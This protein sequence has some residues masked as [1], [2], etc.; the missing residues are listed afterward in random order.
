LKWGDAL[1]IVGSVITF[2]FAAHTLFES[3]QHWIH[4]GDAERE[5][6][7][8]FLEVAMFFM[9]GLIFMLGSFFYW[10]GIYDW[11]CGEN[12]DPTRLEN[13][14]FNGESWGAFLFILGSVGFS[15]AAMLN[16]MGM[17]LN[18][19]E[20][21]QEPLLQVCHYLHVVALL[22]AQ[23][24]AVM[25]TC[26][27][28]LYRPQ[29]NEGNN[30]CAEHMERYAEGDTT[31]TH[32]ETAHVCQSAGAYGTTLYIVGSICYVI[33]AFLNFTCSVLKGNYVNDN[34]LGNKPVDE[35]EE[36]EE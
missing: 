27:S 34:R 9:A 31:A 3:R 21:S 30:G 32:P 28:F 11:W 22:C 25:F 14:E 7:V 23:I 4:Y 26:G 33:E 2:V 12:C 29:I 35:D 36:P 15:L 18:K 13:M 17:G 5:D 24:G 19:Q 8:E 16:A 1:F 6:R 10:P 20:Q